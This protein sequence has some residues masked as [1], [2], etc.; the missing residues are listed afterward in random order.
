[1]PSAFL[2]DRALIRVTGADAE[3]FLQ[4]LVTTDLSAVGRHEA[5]PGALLTPQGK[6]L[7]DF[8][9]WRDDAA[10]LIETV[11]A[12][13]EALI[14]RLTLYKLRAA[15]EIS[16]AGAAGMTVFWGEDAAADDI[17]D[18]RFAAAGVT[19]LRRAGQHSD[20]A[21]AAYH[22]LRILNGI[23]ESGLDFELQDAFPHD[24]LLDLNRGVSFKKGCYVGQEVVSRMQHRGTAR[25]RVVIV[26]SAEPLPETGTVITAG[27]KPLGQLGT[28]AGSR[29]LAIVRTDR[30]GDALA[31]GTDILTGDT[32]VSLVLPAWS[33]LS[34]PTTASEEA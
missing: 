11:E 15:V 24:V 4:N 26:S 19:L 13:Q 9:I 2:P 3:H 12:V 22:A 7:F 18:M 6:I 8:L 5:W 29:G 32:A 17:R 34:F 25:R 16:V 31:T 33:G 20:G 10:F 21:A 30:V 27:G 14:R 1:M 28:V 23:V